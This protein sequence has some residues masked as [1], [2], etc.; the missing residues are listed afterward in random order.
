[1]LTHVSWGCLYEVGIAAPKEPSANDSWENAKKEVARRSIKRLADVLGIYK[2]D[3]GSYPTTDQGL[4]ALLTRP[5]GVP[6]WRRPYLK[7]ERVPEDPWGQ[8]YIYRAP[9]ERPGHEYD[10]YS[11]G[12]GGSR[13]PDNN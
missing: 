12:G 6:G 1:M 3:V 8:P 4:Q 11:L 5:Q 7:G 2:L 13:I 10:L 9:S